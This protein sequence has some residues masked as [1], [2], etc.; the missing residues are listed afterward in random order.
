[1]ANVENIALRRVDRVLLRVPSVAGAVKYYRDVMGM[2]LVKEDVRLASL[3]FSES[4]TELV[5]H[6]DPDLPAEAV[7]YL[8]DDVRGLYAKREALKVQFI[9][10]PKPGARGFRAEI[11]DPFGNV[12][13]IVDRSGEKA[14][15]SNS[16]TVIEDAKPPG[17]LFAGVEEKKSVDRELLVKVYEEIG[18]TADDLPYTPDFEKLFAVYAS[19]Q[20]GS[21]PTREEVWRYLLNMRKAGKLPKLGEARSRPPAIEE[22]ERE[23]LKKL[24]GEEMGRRDRL[25]YTDRFDKLCDAFNRSRQRPL[26][27]HLVWRLVAT[28][29]K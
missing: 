9:H 7:Y 6:C 3:K 26:S 11:R 2:K 5:V 12:L 27:P 17:A 1:M 19:Q 28:M 10:A 13:L 24:I 8:V 14:G 16:G 25:P 23:A 20:K 15:T 18:R 29:A 22:E 21:K 4:D